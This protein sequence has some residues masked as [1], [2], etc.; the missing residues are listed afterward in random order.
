MDLPDSFIIKRG[1]LA[2]GP[3]VLGVF[4]FSF[5]EQSGD[6]DSAVTSLSSERVEMDTCWEGV[7]E[8]E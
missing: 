1:H 6:Y 4:V 7:G 3:L 2:F 8:M 5:Q